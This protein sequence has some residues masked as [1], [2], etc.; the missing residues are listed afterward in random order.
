MSIYIDG[1]EINAVELS[2]TINGNAACAAQNPFKQ[3]HYL[4]LNLALGGSAGGSV[5][6]LP[7][8]TRYMVDYVRVYQ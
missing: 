3:P 7:F 8:P 2:N 1:T 6:N 5:D 4:L